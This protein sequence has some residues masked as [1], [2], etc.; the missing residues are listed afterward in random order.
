MVRKDVIRLAGALTVGVSLMTLY[1][2]FLDRY[3]FVADWSSLTQIEKW[4]FSTQ[5]LRL[6]VLIALKRRYQL[7]PLIPIIMFSIESLLIP[8]LLVFYIVTG[9]PAYALA[10]GTILTAWMGASAIIL[11]PYLVYSFTKSMLDYTSMVGVLSLSALEFAYY[12]FIATVVSEAGSPIIGLTGLG[13]YLVG[14]LKNQI[15]TVGVPMPSY[16]DYM[17]AGSSVLFFLGLL[18]YATLGVHDLGARIRLSYV[19]FIPLIAIMLALLW[20]FVLGGLTAKP[21]VELSSNVFFGLT[22]PTMV[23][24]GIIWG[25]SRGKN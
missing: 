17:I 5:L 12:V 18:I 22:L 8:P 20:V 7:Q 13:A 15:S 9:N 23:V 25:A 3:Y 10:M 16:S 11:S 1:F 2:V 6:I 4:V 21:F 24:A 19:L 14:S